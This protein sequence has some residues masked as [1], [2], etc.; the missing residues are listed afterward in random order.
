MVCV[1]CSCVVV[2]V[3]S[4][5]D[6]VYVE[7][8]VLHIVETIFESVVLFKYSWLVLLSYYV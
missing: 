6:I 2:V 7:T 3:T 1:E 8:S 5:P 4:L